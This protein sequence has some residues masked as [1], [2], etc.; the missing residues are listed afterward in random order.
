M[1]SVAQTITQP[2]ESLSLRGQEDKTAKK[3]STSLFDG[4]L[5]VKPLEFSGALSESQYPR[6]EL[7]PALGERFDA[8]VR[9]KEILALPKEEGDAILRDV[10][11]LISYRGVVFF[12][13]QHDLKK[14]DIGRL[15]LRLGELAGKPEDSTL[16]IHPT[17]KLTETGLP[18][19]KI[20][21]KADAEGRQIS[22]QH[23]GLSSR[24]FHS[25]VAFEPR[26][27]LFTILQ[28]HT[29]PKSG[30]DTLWSSNYN[31]YDRLTPRYKKFLEGLTALNDAD[32][33]RQQAAQNGFQLRTE[34]RG[35]PL[36]A[37][38]A[39]QASH[40][41]I[42]TNPVTGLRAIYVNP[43]F[44]KR[45]NELSEEESR[46]VLDYLFR[47][48]IENHED[49]VKYKWNKYDVAIWNNSVVNHLAT[50]DFGNAD[51]QG[52]RAVVVGETPY[53]DPASIGRREW[54]A[55]KAEVSA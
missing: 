45:I 41:V 35:S 16:H 31:T 42:R 46:S 36:N 48:Q 18:L 32:R 44:T 26:P 12:Q 54:E 20:D 13:D 9:L 6:E 21:A 53:F 4:E 49:H 10:A 23:E 14:E 2:L 43:T 33:F 34:P 50:F 27:A 24:A 15:A 29:I 47:V 11:I 22:F 8:G 7:T 3:S 19:G 40:P 28:M 17:Q 39:F 5:Q 37:G 30:G 51:R 55:R 52:D 38:G 1:P 25:D